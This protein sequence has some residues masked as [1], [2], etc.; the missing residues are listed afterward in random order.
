MGGDARASRLRDWTRNRDAETGAFAAARGSTH[1]ARGRA[2]RPGSRGPGRA[3]GGARDPSGGPGG[4]TPRSAAPA[5]CAA[6]TPRPPPLGRP[7][8]SAP[9]PPQARARRRAMHVSTGP[10]CAGN[11]GRSL[12]CQP[13]ASDGP[14]RGAVRWRHSRT[15]PPPA[16]RH[17]HPMPSSRSAWWP[18]GRT[19]PY[20]PATPPPP[21]PPPPPSPPPSPPLPLPP[22]STASTSATAP[23]AASAAIS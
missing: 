19:S 8:R 23:P 17:A 4:F 3:P 5:R 10:T 22:P 14:H 11:F 18:G 13:A 15:S 7:G 6:R 1:R 9:V 2:W 16:P 20:A 21:P 12:P